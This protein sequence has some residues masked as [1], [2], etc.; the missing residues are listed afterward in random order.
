M[1]N[2]NIYEAPPPEVQTVQRTFT[3]IQSNEV[4]LTTNNGY[5]QSGS[6]V[7]FITKNNSKWYDL[8]GAYLEVRFKVA[9]QTNVGLNLADV[10][11]LG[12]NSGW[13][14]FSKAELT[15]GGEDPIDS[16]DFPGFVHQAYGLA[17]YAPSQLEAAAENEWFYVEKARPAFNSDV[18]A[19]VDSDVGYLA[20]LTRKMIMGA[21]QPYDATAYALADNNLLAQN[22]FNPVFQHKYARTC[23][24]A[25][26]DSREV[27]LM[28]PLRTVFGFAQKVRHP[29]RGIPIQLRLTFEES[30]ASIMH[31]VNGAA[32][33]K[34]VVQRAS[35]WIPELIPSAQLSAE[36]DQA[37]YSNAS[38]PYL[39]ENRTTFINTYVDVPN[40]NGTR[41][42]IKINTLAARP[43]VVFVSLQNENQFA[44]QNDRAAIATAITYTNGAAAMSQHGIA[45]SGIFSHL[46][47]I[48]QIQLRVNS[49]K[50]PDEPYEII[51]F[52][53]PES[54]A[55][56]YRDFLSVMYKDNF[57]MAN[58][59]DQVSWSLSPTFAFKINIDEELYNKVRTVDL[60]LDITLKS[61][62]ANATNPGAFRVISVVHSDRDLQYRM[63]DGRA[64]MTT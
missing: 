20:L 40:V 21:A 9:R 29:L 43:S 19:P 41:Y 58:V 13:S 39:F 51:S 53:S 6:Q 23:A 26:G 14:L 10:V 34:P 47:D 35:L 48:S 62:A 25:D 31:G 37:L 38:V 50:Y 60:V 2:W 46:L 32:N 24:T 1:A 61:A 3:E 12:A 28:L 63:V 45:N 54:Y 59:I 44:N 33:C 36:L 8:H 49:T 64:I 11:T 4:T 55:R 27:T 30:F 56:A 17:N 42:T 57:D 5:T 22:K 15:L 18:T 16:V 7:N 52:G